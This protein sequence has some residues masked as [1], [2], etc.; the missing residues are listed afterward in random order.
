MRFIKHEF[1]KFAEKGTHVDTARDKEMCGSVQCSTCDWW[2]SEVWFKSSPKSCTLNPYY[3]SGIRRLQD[4]RLASWW[5]DCAVLINIS[6]GWTK[7]WEVLAH[8][9]QLQLERKK[10]GC[11]TTSVARQ[12]R[13]PDNFGCPTTSVAR[14]F[15]CPTTSVARQLLL[16]NLKLG[17]LGKGFENF[18]I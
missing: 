14:H 9:Q 6:R 18:A 8:L 1:A 15:C 7:R 3:F 2:F 13:L 16:S 10:F 17:T 5:V 4:L 12:L 11:P